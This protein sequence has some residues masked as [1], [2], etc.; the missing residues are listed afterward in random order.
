MPVTDVRR[1]PAAGQL[2]TARTIWAALL[3]SPVMFAAVAVTL[4]LAGAAPAPTGAGARLPLYYAWLAVTLVGLLGSIRVR[5][6]ALEALAEVAAWRGPD[7]RP[8][9][10]EEDRAARA[11]LGRLVVAWALLEGPALLGVVYFLL[12]GARL[13][14]LAALVL[15]AGAMAAAYPRRDWFEALAAGSGPTGLVDG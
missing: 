4:R 11:L 9:V 15:H 2:A 13:V 5:R 6:R 3:L 14:L 10:E 12:T 1:S 8:S 7:P